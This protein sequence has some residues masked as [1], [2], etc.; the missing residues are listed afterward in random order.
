MWIQECRGLYKEFVERVSGTRVAPR[1]LEEALSGAK[2]KGRIG[3]DELRIIEDSPDW[4]YPQWWPRLSAQFGESISLAG[5]KK[6]RVE[7][8]QNRVKYIEVVSVI[9]RFVFPEEFGIISPPVIG[10][11]NLAP[12]KDHEEQ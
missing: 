12:G 1:R 4:P 10:L 3:S 7:S 11:L 2:A 5:D 6:G 9:L 8:L